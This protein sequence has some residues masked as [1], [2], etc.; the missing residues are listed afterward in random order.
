MNRDVTANWLRQ[1]VG[2]YQNA[3][4]VHTDVLAALDR[5]PSLRPKTDVYT[6]DD[7][8]T[9]LL[10]C[11]HGLLPITFRSASYNIPIAIW[12]VLSYPADPPL[13]YVVP[14]SDM[15]VRPSAQVDHSG[16][17]SIDYIT[18]WH[19]KP[20]ACSLTSLL[21]SMQSHFSS[22]PPL[23]AKSRSRPSGRLL[24]TTTS[25][26]SSSAAYRA[27]A[28]SRGHV[29]QPDESSAAPRLPPKPFSPSPGSVVAPGTIASVLGSVPSTS[30]V[31]PGQSGQ[32]SPASLSQ[33]PASTYSHATGTDIRDSRPPPVPPHPPGHSPIFKAITSS[34]LAPIVV[35]HD[36]NQGTQRPPPYASGSPPVPP[37]PVPPSPF[38]H[39]TVAS[40]SPVANGQV[41]PTTVTPPPVA[42]R[43]YTQPPPL[44]L[45]P[46]ISGL[47]NKAAPHPTQ[48]FANLPSYQPPPAPF[49]FQSA[50]ARPPPSLPPPDLL[51]EDDDL[52][53]NPPSSITGIESAPPPPRPP[54]PQTV[55]LHNALLSSF[56]DAVQRLATTH[57]DTLARQRAAQVEL[58]AAPEA[59]R[60]ESARLQAVRDVCRVVGDRW[61]TLVTDGECQLGELRRRGEVSVDEMV[62]ASSIV[63]NQLI[64]LVAEDNAIED[65]IYHLHRA[66]NSG[67]IDLERFL[68]T[69]R[70]LAEEQFLKRALIE[71]ILRGLPM[72]M[73]LR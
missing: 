24:S 72:G 34:A 39:Q 46:A 14:T 32:S 48:Q 42:P 4:R 67:R 73:A 66:L 19:R 23:Y 3:D 60:D 27:A 11:V 62:C 38:T 16:K 6:F 55:A 37:P 59:I 28:S 41:H 9:Q 45:Q 13:V 35:S 43:P 58:L 65:T 12:L 10:L 64:N 36:A 15:L 40:L 17:C 1:N 31:S 56:R 63:G 30:S 70:V 44:P 49:Q 71:K 51:D 53:A 20:E 2:R 54:N 69:T 7:G 33:T 21:E 5:Y 8:R 47:T 50:P 26:S 68:R 57:A 22:E 18:N 25:V 52:R 61:E 29:S